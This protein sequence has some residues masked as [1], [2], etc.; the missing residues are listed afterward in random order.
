MG[1]IPELELNEEGIPD[2]GA[3][4]DEALA[5]NPNFTISID[6]AEFLDRNVTVPIGV[7]D[8]N[9]TVDLSRLIPFLNTTELFLNTTQIE[10][11][12]RPRVRISS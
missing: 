2:L 9:V 10:S 8:L 12:I 1:V 11:A 5:A 3:L 4:L 7:G 6:L